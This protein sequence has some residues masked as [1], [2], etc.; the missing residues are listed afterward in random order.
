MDVHLEEKNT[1]VSAS[2]RIPLALSNSLLCHKVEAARVDVDQAARKSRFALFV[3]R[4]TAGTAQPPTWAAP[5]THDLQ[6]QHASH[7]A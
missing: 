2:V 1:R 4:R 5:L 7:K 3:S 6:H